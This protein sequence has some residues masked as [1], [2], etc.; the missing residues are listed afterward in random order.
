MIPD[1][2]SVVGC[3]WDVLPPGIHTAILAEVERAFAINRR[4]QK[5]FE[6]L[7]VASASLRS[8]GCNR[9]FLD[10]SYVTG[11]PIPGDYDACWDP[12]GIDPKKLDP[13]FRDFSNQR[14]AQ[15]Q[16][17]GG[18]FFPSTMLNLPNQ[19]FVVFFQIERFTG[20]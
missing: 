3:P 8:A 10:G 4:R 9:I 19:P 20:M 18:E 7:L 17:F 12:L 11:K 1:L 13:V 15:K 14:Q 2:V 5:L 6:G 16:K